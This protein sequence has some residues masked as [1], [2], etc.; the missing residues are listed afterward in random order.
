MSGIC[1]CCGYNLTADTAV[2]IGSWRIEPRNGAYHAGKLVVV[3]QSWTNILLAVARCNGAIISTEALLART[4]DAERN[5][6][7]A[8]QIS[9]LRRHLREQGIPMPMEGQTRPGGYRWSAAA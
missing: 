5:N 3:R 8:S 9:Q 4:S 7:L 1:P 6:A 2:E